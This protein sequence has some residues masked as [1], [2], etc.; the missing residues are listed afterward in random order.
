MLRAIG[1]APRRESLLGTILLRRPDA[2]ALAAAALA[3]ASASALALTGAAGQRGV[4]VGRPC[5][6]DRNHFA[7]RRITQNAGNRA[8]P[9]QG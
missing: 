4:A 6:Q 2:A 8:V 5:G 3:C 7:D 9:R 1:F